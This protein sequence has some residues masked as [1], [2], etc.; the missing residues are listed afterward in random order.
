MKDEAAWI[1]ERFAEC[2]IA[3]G[4]CHT[5]NES[6]RADLFVDDLE[7][8]YA[9]LAKI[10]PNPAEWLRPLMRTH[11]SPWVQLCAAASVGR[12]FPGEALPILEALSNQDGLWALNS[13]LHL[14]QLRRVTH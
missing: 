12:S 14:D 13:R 4:Y 3:W 5:M 1:V 11:P 7:R 9:Q 2:A 6:K 8:L 10:T